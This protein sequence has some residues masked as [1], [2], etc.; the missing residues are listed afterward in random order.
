MI[1][2]FVDDFARFGDFDGAIYI[3]GPQ[4]KECATLQHHGMAASLSS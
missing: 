3:I 1:Q 4:S 2:R